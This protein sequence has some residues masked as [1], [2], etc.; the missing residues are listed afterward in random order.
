MLVS[1]VFRLLLTVQGHG[2]AL[3]IRF[4]SCWYQ[5]V[6]SHFLPSLLMDI[7]YEDR[8]VRKIKE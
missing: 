1:R 4:R 3:A 5:S 7:G 8:G 6:P 2:Y